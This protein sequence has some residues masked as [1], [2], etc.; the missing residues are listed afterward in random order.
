ME[1][2]QQAGHYAFQYYG[3]D[4]GVTITVFIGIFLIGD[5]KRSGFVV[6]MIS[7]IF[8]LIFSYQIGSIANAVTSFI[9][10]LLYFRGFLKW[11]KKATAEE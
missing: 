10:F 4:W 6:G 2:L 5:K 8:G 9:I 3:I 7:A 11:Q 1:L